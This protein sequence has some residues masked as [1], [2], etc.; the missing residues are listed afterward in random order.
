MPKY[1]IN[2]NNNLGSSNLFHK[3]LL[4]KFFALALD[5]VTPTIEKSGI[6]D[7]WNFEDYF[8]GK[9]DPNFVPVIPNVDKLVQ[10]EGETGNILVFDFVAESFN[11]FQSLFKLPLKFGK[12]TEATPITSPVP[13]KGF[14][15]TET[16]YQ[17]HIKGF[18]MTINLVNLRKTP[19]ILN[20]TF[21]I[22]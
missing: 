8:Y 3:R 14:V 5:G 18:T 15:D 4:Y 10:L 21:I 2:A 16:L 6:K 22:R 13:H 9:V 7:Y 17:N 11:R 12:L 19:Y 20:Q 1:R